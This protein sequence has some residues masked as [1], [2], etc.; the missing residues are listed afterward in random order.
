M[1]YVLCGMWCVV[2]VM[3]YVSWYVVCVMWCVFGRTANKLT[4]L[5]NGASVDAT[6]TGTITDTAF[7]HVVLT[8][9]GSTGNWTITFAI[10]G[11]T[12]T[13][14]TTVNPVAA[15]ISGNVAIGRFGDFAGGYT[16]A[17]VGEVTIYQRAL[18][19]PEIYEVFRSGNGAIGRQ[20]TGQTR[21]RVYGFVP[22]AFRAYWARRQNQ[23][24]GGGV[25]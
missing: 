7:H 12:S 3:C 19:Q 16:N 15:S 1:C 9:N 22:A 10:D 11:V 25:R 20:L 5:Q 21:R 8:R 18:T 14:T 17:L 24:V 4:W 23:I 13:H 6:S 2:C